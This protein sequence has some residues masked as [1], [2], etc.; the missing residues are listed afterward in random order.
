MLRTSSLPTHFNP[1][2]FSMADASETRA[3]R[4]ACADDQTLERA[5][6]R[7]FEQDEHIS[8]DFMA[9]IKRRRHHRVMQQPGM[10]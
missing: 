2:N 5:F 9:E 1:N 10:K 3:A 8:P 4:L 6:D 7:A